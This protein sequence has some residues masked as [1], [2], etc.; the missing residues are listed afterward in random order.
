MRCSYLKLQLGKFAVIN[1]MGIFA[2]PAKGQPPS[3]G[4][5]VYN[6]LYSKICNEFYILKLLPNLIV[7]VRLLF[8]GDFTL[9]ARDCYHRCRN[10]SKG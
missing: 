1:R 7:C 3:S 6:I 8:L 2:P 9:Y 5:P 4:V 10:K